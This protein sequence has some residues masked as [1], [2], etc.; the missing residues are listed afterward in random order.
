MAIR[1]KEKRPNLSFGLRLA[2]VNLV[3]GWSKENGSNR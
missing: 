1:H 3:Y 2:A